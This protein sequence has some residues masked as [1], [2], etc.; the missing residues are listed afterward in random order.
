MT[1]D[2]PGAGDARE[3]SLGA[4]LAGNP[5]TPGDG[6]VT[7][8]SETDAP[9]RQDDPAGQEESVG[10]DDPTG[11][12]EPVGQEEPAGNDAGAADAA[13]DTATRPERVPERV[14]VRQ[15][16]FWSMLAGGIVAAGIGVFAAPY[17]LP[18]DWFAPQGAGET[19]LIE[20]ISKLEGQLAKLEAPAER[21]AE[22][23]GLRQTLTGL[24]RRL[25]DLEARVAD[26]AA[27]PVP[28]DSSGAVPDE[29]IAALQDRLARQQGAIDE[30]RDRFEARE[31]AARDSARAMLRRAA[32][33]RIGTALDS[34]APFAPALADLRETGIEVPAALTAV[35]GTGV[36]THAGLVESFPD[37]ARAALAAA[38]AE[39]GEGVSMTDFLRAQLGMRSLS[40]REG[41]DPDAVLSRAEAA[42]VQGRLSDALAEIGTLP[43][44]A[45]AAMSQWAA[46]A[47]LRVEALA[48]FE[49]LSQALN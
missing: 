26:L 44:S 14:T 23:D 48:A 37:A 30:L 5:D 20:R 49:S 40:P 7:Q 3:D 2:D 36:P 19:Q 18:P 10:Q 17:V 45:R 25:A 42:L 41:D 11:Q 27:R 46:Q 9:T 34:G 6:S 43:E 24:T 15:G 35:A 12:E 13:P 31:S 21:S 22:I 47:R 16:G 28:Q 8:S 32:L 1:D 29:V 38:R 33:T 4:D 39:A